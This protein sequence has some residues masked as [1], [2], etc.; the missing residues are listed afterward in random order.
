[1]PKHNKNQGFWNIDPPQLDAWYGLVCP[2]TVLGHNLHDMA[3]FGILEAGFCMVFRPA[4]FCFLLTGINF[5]T[6]EPKMGTRDF[7]IGPGRSLG[8]YRKT[9]G[10]LTVK[11]YALAVK[12]NHPCRKTVWALTEKHAGP[13]P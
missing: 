9:P 4:P 10:A 8:P 2:K 5:G 6:R 3:P 11:T 13:L 7:Q 1:M 12:K